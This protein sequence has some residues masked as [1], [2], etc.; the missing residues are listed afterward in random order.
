M[1]L[2]HRKFI[3]LIA[4]VVL[5]AMVVAVVSIL[6][7][8]RT[9]LAMERKRLTQTV[10][11]QVLLIGSVARFD[12]IYSQ[13][14]NPGGA[15]GATISQ[16]RDAYQQFQWFDETGEILIARATED[17]SIEYLNEPRHLDAQSGSRIPT[18]PGHNLPM[19]RALAGESGNMVARDYR[20]K[21]VLASY[22]P[23]PDLGIGLVAKIDMA[24]INAPYIRSAIIVG[25]GAVAIALAGLLLVSVAFPLIR[26]AETANERERQNLLAIFDSIDEPI[27]VSDP[28]THELLYVNEAFK[29]YWGDGIGQPCY[30][31]INGRSEPCE[32]CTTPKIF[33][34]NVGQTCT[35]EWYNAAT[36]Q[37]FRC[38]DKA[39]HWPGHRLVRYEMAINITAE[40][41][42]QQAV[43]EQQEKVRALSSQLSLSEER[44]RKR[45][46]TQLH[47]QIGHALVAAKMNLVQLKSAE[48]ALS[49]SR[50]FAE[51]VELIERTI[52]D[53]R[54]LTFEISPPVLHELGLDPALEWLVEQTRNRYGLQASYEGSKQLPRLD[55]ELAVLLF[56]AT[57]ELLFNVYKHAQAQQAWVRLT[58]T[59]DSVAVEVR[60]DGI[61]F[62]DPLA[63][64]GHDPKT[65]YGLLSILERMRFLD[66]EMV[67]RSAPGRGTNVILTAPVKQ[68]RAE[69]EQPADI[70]A[71]GEEPDLPERVVRVLIADDHALMRR[72]IHS[73]LAGYPRIE[74]AGE[75]VDGQEAQD[76]AV[77]LLPDVVVMDIDMPNVDGVAAT[78]AILAELPTARILALS[79]HANRHFVHQML[80]AGASGY[81][82]KDSA[83]E[84]LPRAI[85]QVDAGQIFLSPS[86]TGVLVDEFVLHHDAAAQ[87]EPE[88][89]I[90]SN[91]ELEVLRLI[92]NGDSTK[93][94]AFTLGISQ[95]TAQAHRQNMMKKLGINSTAELVQLAIR[96]G[97]IER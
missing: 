41:Q 39:I 67:V 87:A 94:I 92:A 45:L 55:N 20:D 68:P 31:V 46:A 28:L 51:I 15:A 85:E 65:G 3:S 88:V 25:I 62:A 66:G 61:G 83:A 37:W 96:E 34:T 30:E 4:T 44:E 70:V 32:D 14:D 72:G 82:L 49:Q 19:S 58:S 69:A 6:H 77:E 78:R 13:E 5:V 56:Q 91:R 76:L 63:Q 36:G 59:A 71:V 29:Q 89:S 50:Q 1:T 22:A 7:L 86:I 23:V 17:H 84:D 21:L 24:E 47:D 27:Y 9:A 16:L 48:A 26:Q 18:D 12:A 97:L 73:I 2:E 79:M 11:S 80:S 54:S 10:E 38:L 64:V 33:G 60:D 90:L 81:L 43:A 40:K 52:E 8:Y 75:A 95:K 53:V 93:Q 57:R 74:I 42:A 35:R